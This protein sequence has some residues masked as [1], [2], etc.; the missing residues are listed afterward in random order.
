MLHRRSPSAPLFLRLPSALRAGPHPLDL[1]FAS[2]K[3]WM[4]TVG[5]F[6]GAINLLAL[7]GSIFMLQVYDRVLASRSIPT[8]VVL[9]ALA[10]LLYA[11]Q[12]ALD[13]IRSRLLLRMGARLDE[14]LGPSVY[15]AVLKLPLRSAPQGDGIHLIRDL[16]A[17]KSFLGSQ[18]PS[19]LLDLPWIP[20]YLTFVFVLHPWLGWVATAGAAVLVIVTLTTEVLSRQPAQDA[21][22]AASRRQTLA[23]AGHRN[24]EVLH[25]MGFAERHTKR[26]LDANRHHLDAQ[27][28]AGDVTGG[29]SATSRVFRALL[30]SGLLALG[31]WLTIRGEVSA[32]PSLQVRSSPHEHLLRSTPR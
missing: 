31:A 1:A 32:G 9:A 8:L 4:V 25:A 20:I 18:G 10:G 15:R 12:G 5:A 23:L 24:A 7:T 11:I 14:L 17:I 22:L 29:F 19:A 16:D 6:S 28:S 30:Q 3:S 26:W 27:I 21:A 2:L 13:L